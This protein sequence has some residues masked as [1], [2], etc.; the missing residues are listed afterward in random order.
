MLPQPGLRSAMLDFEELPGFSPSFLFSFSLTILKVHDFKNK[1]SLGNSSL[2]MTEAFHR[3]SFNI[4]GS[5]GY[6]EIKRSGWTGF[7]YSCYVN[8]IALCEA[9]Q[10][11]ASNQDEVIFTTKIVETTFIEDSGSGDQVS[12]YVIETTRVEDNVKTTVHR[13]V[14]F[15]FRAI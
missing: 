7:V 12:W 14:S 5:A 9:T 1:G 8:D 3:I 11:V 2:L 4:A 6:I 15:F 13:S 10:T